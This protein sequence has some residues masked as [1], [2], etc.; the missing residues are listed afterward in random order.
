LLICDLSWITFLWASSSVKIPVIHP[1]CL[2]YIHI[3][4]AMC[5][6]ANSVLGS[7]PSE[8]YFTPSIAYPN[9]IVGLSALNF[10]HYLCVF[11]SF[12]CYSFF[13]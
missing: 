12:I 8:K 3:T 1:N 7:S 10:I 2:Q 9:E 13:G 6:V 5:L 11:S 4:Q